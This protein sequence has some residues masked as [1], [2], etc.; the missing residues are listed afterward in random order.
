MYSR[1]KQ[2]GMTRSNEF[3]HEKTTATSFYLILLDIRNFYIGRYA[4]YC[5]L[6]G[7]RKIV[8]V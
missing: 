4:V 8:A 2:M 3:R 1:V 6:V 7:G 5:V